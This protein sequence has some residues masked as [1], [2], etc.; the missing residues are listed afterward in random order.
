V[1][2]RVCLSTLCSMRC[3]ARTSKGFASV[4]LAER[5]AAGLPPLAHLAHGPGGGRPDDEA[6]E[7]LPR[8]RRAR[9]PGTCWA[10]GRQR[11]PQTVR[12]RCSRGARCRP[13]VQRVAGQRRWQLMLQ[14]TATPCRCGPRC[15]APGVAPRLARTWPH[16]ACAGGSMSTRNR[17]I[18]RELDAA[19]SRPGTSQR[20]PCR[21]LGRRTVDTREPPWHRPLSR[22]LAAALPALAGCMPPAAVRRP[23][24]RHRQRACARPESV[25]GAARR[26]HLRERDRRVSAR[27]ATAPS[28]ASRMACA[29]STRVASTTP[30][31]WPSVLA[32]S[33]WQ[34]RTT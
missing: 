21:S 32:S 12:S 28:S 15:S 9:R 14:S 1:S 13:T 24:A 34:T 7:A 6:C 16:A 22:I 33:T 26:H 10:A 3:C 31:D 4:Q 29:A 20:G 8:G 11:S 18:S 27:T 2:R 25:L 5:R 19:A 23:G 17:V 30:R